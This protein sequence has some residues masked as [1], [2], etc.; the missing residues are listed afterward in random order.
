MIS[1]LP[2]FHWSEFLKSQLLLLRAKRVGAMDDS[3][4]PLNTKSWL[5]FVHQEARRGG[6]VNKPQNNSGVLHKTAVVQLPHYKTFLRLGP[7]GAV[8]ITELIMYYTKFSTRL[9]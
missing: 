5:V 9:H 3:D 8:Q 6:I 1:R 4:N 7:A 2:S